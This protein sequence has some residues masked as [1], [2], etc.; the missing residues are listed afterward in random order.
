MI[1]LISRDQFGEIR[2][3][4]EYGLSVIL[5]KSSLIFLWY[6]FL[7]HGAGLTLLWIGTCHLFDL[8]PHRDQGLT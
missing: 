7:Q 8:S 1:A 6:G 5:T 3:T 2:K 4:H